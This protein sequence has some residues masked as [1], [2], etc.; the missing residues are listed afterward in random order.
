MIL[1]I[2]IQTKKE[3][4]VGKMLSGLRC[5]PPGLPTGSIPQSTHRGERGELTALS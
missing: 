3:L 4:R 1:R 2:Q 5:L